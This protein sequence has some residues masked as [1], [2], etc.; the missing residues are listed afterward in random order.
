MC[1]GHSDETG[2]GDPHTRNGDLS[3]Q[4]FSINISSKLTEGFIRKLNLI[5]IVVDS[6]NIC[7]L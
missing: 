1:D 3:Y 2:K 4:N 5:L 7:D 6:L